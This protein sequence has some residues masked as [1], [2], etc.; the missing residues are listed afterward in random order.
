MSETNGT[1]APSVV[2]TSEQMRKD[3]DFQVH[4]SGKTGPLVGYKV[5]VQFESF[6][7]ILECA[8]RF[9]VWAEQKPIREKKVIFPRDRRVLI[10][11][12]GKFQ[13]TNE[14]KLAESLSVFESMPVEVQKA[15]FD[16]MLKAQ[17]LQVAAIQAL[18][19]EEPKSQSVL[20]S[21]KVRK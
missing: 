12:K 17:G 18:V 1:K 19:E 4:E 5:T 21:A 14:E 8:V 10:D 2:L 6:E 13:K 11:A 9:V 7:E 3:W 16:K 20:D 15:Y